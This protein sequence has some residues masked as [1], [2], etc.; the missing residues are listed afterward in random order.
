MQDTFVDKVFKTKYVSV[1]WT[2]NPKITPIYKQNKI[3]PL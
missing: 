3:T 1:N 2:E